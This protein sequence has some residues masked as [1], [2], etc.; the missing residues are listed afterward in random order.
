MFSVAAGSSG[1][2]KSPQPLT[3]G[4]SFQNQTR[5]TQ[6]FNLKP[7]LSL[8]S[9]L[10]ME[11]KGD[12]D[13]QDGVSVKSPKSATPKNQSPRLISAKSSEF[14]F[15]VRASNGILKHTENFVTTKNINE[16]KTKIQQRTAFENENFHFASKSK[17][18]YSGSS[19]KDFTEN[20][21][22]SSATI[23]NILISCE[24]GSSKSVDCK[25]SEFEEDNPTKTNL[26]KIMNEINDPNEMQILREDLKDGTQETIEVNGSKNESSSLEMKNSGRVK[27][28]LEKKLSDGK[29]VRGLEDESRRGSWK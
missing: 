4:S 26:N 21:S 14:D 27:K 18:K 3:R 9:V 20:T 17:P 7:K 19:L 23:P 16:F 10:D 8:R 28:D 15:N 29:K 5:N 2:E 12:G 24:S 13:A 25:N 22:S 6:K 11:V 1:D